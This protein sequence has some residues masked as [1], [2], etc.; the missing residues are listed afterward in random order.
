MTKLPLENYVTFFFFKLYMYTTTLWHL[1]YLIGYAIPSRLR[2]SKN[3]YVN[4]YNK[5]FFVLFLNEYSKLLKKIM[6]LE[7]NV[8]NE[9]IFVLVRP[10]IP[11]SWRCFGLPPPTR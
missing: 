10:V 11:W 6:K 2:R 3:I 5:F 7:K 9:D 4:E 1:T 8:F